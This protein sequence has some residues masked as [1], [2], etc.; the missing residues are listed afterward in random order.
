MFPR[1][2]AKNSRHSKLLIGH[3]PYPL[4]WA[5]PKSSV[6]FVCEVLHSERPPFAVIVLVDLV[7]LLYD[8]LPPRAGDRPVL[9]RRQ[10]RGGGRGA[11]LH[12]QILQHVDGESALI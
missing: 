2:S 6:I 4:I 9:G 5:P 11:R 12:P 1:F 3:L 7:E 10:L 8:Q